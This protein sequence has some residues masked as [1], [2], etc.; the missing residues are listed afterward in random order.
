M[1]RG[2]FFE[3]SLV[4]RNSVLESAERFLNSPDLQ[5]ERILGELVPI[6]TVFLVP[7]SKPWLKTGIFAGTEKISVQNVN[8][9]KMLSINEN[10]IL[11]WIDEYVYVTL[12]FKK[13]TKWAKQIP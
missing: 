13:Y 3:M 10:N 4:V 5:Q 8:K 11:L 6:L 12:F 2:E 9:D 1:R 7:S